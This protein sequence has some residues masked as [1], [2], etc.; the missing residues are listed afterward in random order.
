MTDKTTESKVPP[1]IVKPYHPEKEVD[2]LGELSMVGLP[3]V[4]VAA[5]IIGLLVHIF[6]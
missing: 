2:L 5:A 3:I 1:H 4:V 6:G